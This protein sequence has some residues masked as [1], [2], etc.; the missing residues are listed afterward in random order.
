M[1]SDRAWKHRRRWPVW[2]RPVAAIFILAIAA[3]ATNRMVRARWRSAE[4]EALCNLLASADRAEAGGHYAEALASL[5]GA[6]TLVSQKSDPQHDRNALKQRRDV[7]ARKE[8]EAR[9]MTLEKSPSTEDPRRGVGNALTLLA[10]CR[11][12]AALAGLEERIGRT[13]D[14]FRL[15]SAEGDLKFARNAFDAGLYEQALDFSMSQYRTADDLPK[16]DRERLQNASRTL[17]ERIIV[18]N[19]TVVSPF[20]GQFTYGSNASYQERIRSALLTVLR[21]RGYLL[22]PG[23][24]PW[25]D[26]WVA[27]SP[28]QVTISLNELQND[29]YLQSPNRLSHI[30]GRL[31][32]SFQGRQVWSEVFKGTTQV[33]LPHLSAYQGSRLAVSDRRSPEFERVLYDDA[34]ETMFDRYLVSLRHLPPFQAPVAPNPD[35]D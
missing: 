17:A 32:M 10:R 30:E 22:K 6:L 31:L 4:S 15:R 34:F 20:Q 8:A 3:A 26:L 13:L 35:S 27:K 19:G 14:T 25:D 16:L 28:Y 33:P 24:S 7:L 21:E 12:D 5:E 11:K 2:V 23:S 9:L 18:Q 1:R 29:V